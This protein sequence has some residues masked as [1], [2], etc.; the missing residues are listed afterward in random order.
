M[1]KDKG[2]M[3]Q[4]DKLCQHIVRSDFNRSSVKKC[5]GSLVLTFRRMKEA[6]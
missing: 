1:D 4:S 2:T 3:G 6:E 5:N